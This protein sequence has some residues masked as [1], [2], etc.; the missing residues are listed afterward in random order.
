MTVRRWPPPVPRIV[1]MAA[2]V[3]GLAGFSFFHNRLVK[4][5]PADQSTVT[6][7][8]KEIRLWFAE[9]PEPALSR[10][11]LMT[12]DSTPVTTGKV[13]KTDDPLSIAVDVTGAMPAGRYL[14]RWRTSGAD[15]HVIQGTFRFSVGK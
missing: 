1:A 6:T 13:R 5:T 7:A 14:V 15:G 9:A 8:P 11:A 12:A 4:S 3:A 2:L 10:V